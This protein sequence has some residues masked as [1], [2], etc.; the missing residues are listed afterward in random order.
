M[1]SK[2]LRLLVRG[3]LPRLP[4]GRTVSR[5]RMPACWCWPGGRVCRP[6]S[7]RVASLTVSFGAFR[8]DLIARGRAGDARSVLALPAR[9]AVSMS[10]DNA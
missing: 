8:L 6:R 7:S 5:S 4:R 3:G 10:Y 1:A 2:R 9:I